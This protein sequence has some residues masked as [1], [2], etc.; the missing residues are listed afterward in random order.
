MST[1][2][3]FDKRDVYD[4]MY[5]TGKAIMFTGGN[6][7]HS[8]NIS[9][10]H[11]DDRESFFMTTSGSQQGSLVPSD[12]V[13]LKFDEVSWG[14]GR[15]STESTIHRR[16]LSIP[17]TEAAIHCHYLSATAVSFDTK[18][19]QNFLAYDGTADGLDRFSFIP[20]D[21]TGSHLLGAVSSD[22]YLEPTGSKEME[23]RI[24][25]YLEKSPVTLVQG[26][27][28]FVRGDC[29]ATCLHWLGLVEASASLKIAARLRGIDTRA[30]SERIRRDGADALYP[31]KVRPF[32]ASVLGQYDTDDA[33]T[34]SAFKERARFNFYN[35]ISPFG[36]GSMSEKV[37]QNEMLYCPTAAA[38]EGFE[39]SIARMDLQER[40]EDDYELALHKAIYRNTSYK[41]CMFTLSPLGNAEAMAVIFESF[42]IEALTHPDSV[43]IDYSD[44]KDHPVLK[45]I[46][47]EAVYLNPRVGLT[48]SDASFDVI[49][50]MLRW[51]KGACVIAGRGGVGVGS[52]SLEQAAHHVAS[53]E[54]IARIRQTV[55]LNHRL[56]GAPPV[57]YFEPATQ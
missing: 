17:G 27:G 41:T 48:H 2:K 47:A 21:C 35:S 16:I 50:N 45:P 24:P 10:R 19:H 43:S 57:S 51:H 15:A 6:N 39:I 49:A 46:D 3:Q 20:I 42:G 26:H 55:Y 56:A 13:P 30:I 34:I 14:D 7:T 9:L 53:L 36:T 8:G 11:P 44:P 29:L 33:N 32:D 25:V 40:P 18:E 22:Y 28:P 1:E 5:A 54:N 38:P 23:D 52:V 4:A 31:V 12:I 37:T